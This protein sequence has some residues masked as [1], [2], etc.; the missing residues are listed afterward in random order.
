MTDVIHGSPYD[1]GQADSWYNR[2]RDPHKGGVGG[3][4]GPRVE[5]S[6]LTEEEIK[7]YHEGYDWNE[8]FGG[9]KYFD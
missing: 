5:V 1:R 2:P 8:K 6:G 7:A 3:D 4:S 9:K